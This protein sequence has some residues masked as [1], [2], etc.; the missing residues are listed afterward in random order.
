MRIERAARNRTALLS[1]AFLMV[2][3][4]C[5]PNEAA[6]SG[7]GGVGGSGGSGGTVNTS[8]SG[9]AGGTG[10]GGGSTTGSS[11]SG[12]GG[13][14]GISVGG[15]GS[16]GGSSG[17]SG[18]GSVGGSGGAPSLLA[19]G[20]A[21]SL[22]SECLSNFCVDAVCCNAACSGKCASCSLAG[23]LG[24]C[25]M[26]PAGSDPDAECSPGVCD[27]Y[28]ACLSPGQPIGCQRYGDALMDQA[29]SVAADSAGNVIVSGIFSGSIDFGGGPLMGGPAN[30]F[31]AK[32]DPFGNQ[33]WSKSFIHKG[34]AY[35]VL[36]VMI[37]GAN[38]IILWGSLDGEI[39]FGGGKLAS[40]DLHDLA[41]AK[42]AG[43]SGAHMWSKMYGGTGVQQAWDAAL[44][45][46][47]N[48]VLAGSFGGSLSFGGVPLVALGNDAFVAKLAGNNGGHIWSKR[49]GDSSPAAGRGVGVDA[50]GN[51]LLT[52]IYKGALNL[53]GGALPK[54]AMW[55]AVFVSKLT[56]GN[57]A[58]VWSKSFATTDVVDLYDA[59]VDTNGAIVMTG[60]FRG[61]LNFGG[62]KLTV[63]AEFDVF[64]AK[65]D[66]AGTHVFSHR[67]GDKLAQFGT[68]VSTDTAGNV[69]ISGDL[70]GEI[71]LGGGPLKCTGYE[72]AYVGKLD[73][74]GSHLWSKIFT[75]SAMNAGSHL[76]AVA[77]DPA[78]FVLLTGYF[79][80]SVNC[81]GN[82]LI[83]AGSH[84]A[85]VAKLAP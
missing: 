60:F 27:G 48:I 77:A 37:D 58:H 17:G 30:I 69:L 2:L 84:D 20:Q 52:G 12:V 62:S 75:E 31:V 19:N 63:P 9:N 33:L 6:P 45:S 82:K 28:G 34:N 25:T 78:G 72:A 59:T 10:G 79:N 15:G 76:P 74:N 42:L 44:T 66:S 3:G 22:A 26:V 23:T 1:A 47:G 61:D 85:F 55:P 35:D 49:F 68:S 4:A 43:S 11:S 18:G 32:L 53:G 5:K 80:D 71:D 13:S 64:V 14:G 70:M 73:P 38:D 51:V 65:L 24:S 54:P 81:G 21:C 57:A 56:G 29:W 50:A 39:D 7:S 83:S 40:A 46:T 16:V 67:Y 41:V 36:K 8:G